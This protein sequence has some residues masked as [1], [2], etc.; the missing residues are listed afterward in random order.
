[1]NQL[2]TLLFL[3]GNWHGEGHGPYGLYEFEIRVQPRG[4]WLLLTGG[5]RWF[6]FLYQRPGGKYD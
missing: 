1:M 6:V 5:G 2:E 3:E 4:R